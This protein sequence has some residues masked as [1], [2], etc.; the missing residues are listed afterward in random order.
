M[1]HYQFNM[2]DV[3]K[4]V[5]GMLQAESARFDT[6]EAMMRLW[7]HECQRVFSDRFVADALQDSK[8]F[9]DLLSAKLK[10]FFETD[11]RGIMG[12]VDDDEYGPMIVSFMEEGVEGVP[13]EEVTDF[14]KLK[15]RLEDKLEDYNLEPKL[16]SMSL[17]LFKDAVR[18]MCKIHRVLKLQR[19]SM[20]LVGVGGVGRQSCARLASYTAEYGVFMIEIT[21][22]YRMVEWHD[23]MKRL[24]E[25]T[26]VENKPTTFLF[27]DTQIKD[28]GFLEDINN[29]LNAGEIP[30][31]Y[32][33]DELPGIFDGVRKAAIAAGLEETPDQLWKFFVNRVRANLHIILAMSPVGENT[34]TRCRFYPSLINNTT[35][36]WFTSWPQDAL[37][38]VGLRFL[39]GVTLEDESFR[40][41]IAATF[42][43]VHISVEASSDKMLN[44]LKRHNYITPTHFLEL[45]KGY[46][47]LLA[48]KRGQLGAQRDKLSNGLAKLVEARDGVEVMSAEL[49]EKK[50]IVAQKQKDCEALLVVIVSERRAAEEQKKTVEADSERIGKEEV[51]CKAIAD[52]AQQDLAVALPALE[53]AMAEVDKLDKSAISEVKAY[54]KPPAKVELCM[55]CVMIYFG[56]KGDW[57][58][59]KKKLGEAD[60]LVQIKKYD[61][62]NVSPQVVNKV[63]KFVANPEFSPESIGGVSKAA[64]ALC[65]W[66]HAIY[67]YANVAKEVAP[68]RARLK[69]AQDGLAQKQAGLAAAQAQLAEVVAKVES[70]KKQYDDSVGEKN[71]LKAEADSMEMLLDRADKLVKGLAGEYDRWPLMIDPQGQANKWV[72][73]MEESNGLKVIDLKMKNFLLTVENA[74]T[75]GTPIL[76]QDVLEEL[77]PSL[78]PV[79][80]KAIMQIGNR[81]V[82]RLGDKELDYSEDFKL[83]ITTKLGNPHYTPEVSTK[84]T[85]INFAVKQQGLEAQLLGYVVQKE[86]PSLESQKA[87][88]TMRV[89]KGK[90]TLVDLEDEILRLLSETKGSL[91]DDENLVNTLQTSKSTSEEVTQQLRSPRRR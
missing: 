50:V 75:Y 10:D 84:A 59:A 60:F 23:D 15:Q 31:L 74:I 53:K 21:K 67:I 68:K 69:A 37:T 73:R 24:F 48:E 29:I 72:R 42:A 87:E 3:A 43:T 78:E 33:K 91:L 61:K 4:V 39:E 40:E 13:Y 22:Q 26:G 58:T 17:V 49:E 86:Q 18:H 71:Q 36:D 79:L 88:L 2:R 45:V 1:H 83:Y 9:I 5:Q 89:A 82:L 56:G 51:E 66:C 34:R 27:N 6:P 16:L 7:A 76:L 35:I 38:S 65:T 57:D 77:D 81:K 30:N 47:Q 64:G 90:K 28:E 80:A 14:P 70:L 20:M 55:Q 52:D 19:G 11:W 62:D 32:A 8:T 25:K 54:A 85:I 46:K 12:D 44:E 63:K 41:G